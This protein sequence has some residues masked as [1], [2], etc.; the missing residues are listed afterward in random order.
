MEKRRGIIS[1]VLSENQNSK[2]IV[3]QQQQKKITKKKE[4]KVVTK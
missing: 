4:F 2:Y 3:Q 1:I